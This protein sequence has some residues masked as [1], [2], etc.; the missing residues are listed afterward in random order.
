MRRYYLY[1]R[2]TTGV[3][4]VELIDPQGRRLSPRSTKTK[5]RDEAVLLVADWLREGV[6]SRAK[7]RRSLAEIATGE[8]I[9]QAIRSA[10]LDSATAFAIVAELQ[11]RGLVDLEA[12]KKGGPAD[13]P[14]GAWLR[15]FWKYDG[16]YI[17]ERL[18]H[19]QRATKRHCQDME[20]RSREI[21]VM[22]PAG[23]TLGEVKRIHLVNLGLALKTKGL[24]PATVNKT[25][26]A[27]TTAI[28]WA[29]SNELIPTDPTRGLRGFSGASR[30]RGILEPGE[31]K[32]LFST[33]WEDERARVACL[34]A[35]TTGARLGEVLALQFQDIGKDRLFIRH[36]YSIKDG[37][38]T[39]KNGEER[40]VPLLPAVRAALLA[41]DAGNLLVL[42]KKRARIPEDERPAPAGPERFIFAGRSPDRPLDANRI[43]AGM[44]KA[45]VSMNGGFWGD[46]D[47]PQ[48]K[49]AREN[50]LAEYSA[51]GI[52]FHSWRHWY[53]T[54]MA[55]RLDARTVQKATGHKTAAML[56]H[57][58]DHELQED[59]ARLGVAAKE[60]FEKILE[61]GKESN[62]LLPA[63]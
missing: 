9:L 53:A 13:E 63:S 35:A 30:K 5:N 24:A 50:I 18:A 60:A 3:F 15:A 22:L 11:T 14:F 45:L 4:Y 31:V 40:E 47:I 37:L 43:L 26:S 59:M 1:K 61:D 42:E 7:V 23:L 46:D 20:G 58:A 25:L 19:G 49:A 38:K 12:R 36:S 28:R 8:E 56:E 48:E 32:A 62:L 54:N 6:P 27:A 44:R 2:S 17:R 10:P 55:D 39:T 34:V 57:Y 16:T 29:S 51:R 21:E 33:S 41:L 52:D